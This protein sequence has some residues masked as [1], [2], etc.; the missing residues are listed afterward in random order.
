[1]IKRQTLGLMAALLAVAVGTTA[2]VHAKNPFASNPFAG[3]KHAKYTGAGERIPLIALDQNLAVSDTLKGQD[4][5]LPPPQ[6]NVDWPVPGGNLA[7]AMEHVD[8]APNFEVAWRSGF[9]RGSDRI[10][11][12]TATPVVAEGR[13]YTMDGGATVSAFDAKDGRPIWRR[14]LAVR[15][16]REKEAFGGGLAYSDGKLFVTSGYR[17]V[18]AVNPATGEV[19]WRTATEEPIHAAPTAA[20]GRVYAETIGDNLMTFDAGTGQQGWSY[21]AITESARILMAGSPAV[22]GDAVVT[23][24]ASGEL[25]AVQTD[26]G[27]GLW[28]VVLSKSNRNS[29]LSEI[30]DIP[31]R[32]AIYK[33]D[34]YAVSHSGLFDDV[35]LRTG[36]E[37]WSLP[38]TSISS[39]WPAGDVVYATDVSG[40]IICASR[41]NGQVYWIT[42]LNKNVKKPKDRAVWSG[43]V[44]A[45]NRI[46][47]VSDKGEAVALDAKTGALEKTL[48]IGQDS[49]M[50]PIA[51]GGYLYVATQA[52]ELVALR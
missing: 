27:N 9:G 46:V 29:A 14:D 52:G 40:L 42:D 1:M 8:A 37:R 21:Q 32:P 19:L 11:H 45:S 7:Q 22:S 20:G 18:A 4:F 23:A 49:L 30:R 12:V 34:V 36:A 13:I 26:N 38:I 47:V 51:A 28:S 44:L 2:C 35:D 43:P 5:Y 6:A 15:T 31:G 39:A 50:S 24:F 41:E 10:W 3:K 48:R 17:F 25:A 33:G 16:K